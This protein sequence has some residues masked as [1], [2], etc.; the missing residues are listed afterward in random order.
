MNIAAVRTWIQ[1]RRVQIR[2]S[3]HALMEGQKDGLNDADL[4]HA[5]LHGEVIEDY[6]ERALLLDFTEADH[7]P[8]HVIVTVTAYMPDSAEWERDWR[9]RKPRRK[10]GR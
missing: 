8:C 1:Q 2:H 7:L 10:R 9:T 3:L 6:G 5:V 4:E